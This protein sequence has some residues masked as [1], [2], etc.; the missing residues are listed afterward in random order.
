MLALKYVRKPHVQGYISVGGWHRASPWEN[1]PLIGHFSDWAR[2]KIQTRIA[3]G[4]RGITR[5]GWQVE[6]VK[7]MVESRSSQRGVA[8]AACWLLGTKWNLRVLPLRF[9]SIYLE[10][11]RS[12]GSHWATNENLEVPQGL[13]FRKLVLNME[14]PI[15]G[16]WLA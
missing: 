5:Q 13:M 9:R 6:T 10:S 4:W 1:R 2:A 8:M 15:R 11:D 16:E 7:R 12:T 3:S 14:W